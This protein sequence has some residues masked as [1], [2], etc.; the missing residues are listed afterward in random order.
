MAIG[1]LKLPDF[2]LDSAASSV[3][4]AIG[5]IFGRLIIA[6]FVIAAGLALIF[7]AKHMD[8][9]RLAEEPVQQGSASTH[10][11]HT[12]LTQAMDEL[13]FALLIAAGVWLIFE[14]QLRLRS[15][16]EFS[17][18]L[19]SIARNVFDAVLGNNLPTPF[20]DEVKR[21]ALGL[22]FVRRDFTAHYTI[23]DSTYEVSPG[24]QE[25]F[26]KL[27]SEL[28]FTVRNVGASDCP[29]R[30]AAALPNPLHPKLKEQVSVRV[31]DAVLHEKQVNLNRDKA[32]K[33]FR[34][35]LAQATGFNVPYDAG[36]VVLRPG[37]ELFIKIEVVMAKEEEDAELLELVIPCDKLT[38][39]ITETNTMAPRRIFARSVH[40]IE[41]DALP[42]P[43]NP[44]RY[45]LTIDDYFLPHQG[46][47]MGWKRANGRV[48]APPTATSMPAAQPSGS[49]DPAVSEQ[50]IARASRSRR[51]QEPKE[52]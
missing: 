39:S 41:R 48:P 8:A 29:F 42:T 19:S 20:I 4:K 24:V 44:C 18:R 52:R 6:A 36:S 2:R 49:G 1:G 5:E 12:L 28:S 11:E 14:L 21:V 35:N 43:S 3:L 47:L 17:H 7:W 34:I 37:E 27:I 26:V 9:V 50:P 22:S 10:A 40:R 33:E 46:V 45:S 31:I 32:E 30:V 16:K 23:S 15:E 51:G 38:V 25:P 13:G